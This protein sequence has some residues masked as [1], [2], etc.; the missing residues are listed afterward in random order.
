MLHHVTRFSYREQ[1]L[2]QTTELLCQSLAEVQKKAEADHYAA[3]FVGSG[4][5]E[6]M[7]QST[8]GGSGTLKEQL[9]QIAKNGGKIVV[10]DL[11]CGAGGMSEGAAQALEEI[12]SEL[13]KDVEEFAELHAVNHDEEALRAHR[14]NHSWAIH[15]NTGIETLD[16]TNVV[17]RDVTV[18]LLIA[19]P[20]CTQHSPAKGGGPKD[21]DKRSL[22]REIPIWTEHLDVRNVLVENVPAFRRW[23]PL[24]SNDNVVEEK[25]GELFENWLNDLSIQGFNLE[26][27]VLNAADYG[28]ATSRERLFVAGRKDAG[29]DWPEKTHSKDG[30]GDTEEWRPAAE[31][32]DWDDP[33]DSLWIR[34][35]L[36]GRR[37]PLVN[38]TM[39]RIAEGV[40]RHCDDAL[41]P[42]AEVIEQMGRL[43]EAQEERQDPTIS[44]EE[45][46]V[47]YPLELLRERVVSADQAATAARVQS[48]PFLVKFYGTSTA[49]PVDEPLDT[50]TSGGV[51][52]GLCNPQ[53]IGQHGNSIARDVTE[54]PAP[55]VAKAGGISQ[56]RPETILLRQHN[57]AGAHPIDVEDGPA[58][59]IAKAGAISQTRAESMV[60]PK[61]GLCRRLHSNPAYDPADQP[62]HTV[63]A[64]DTRQGYTLNPLLMQYSHGGSLRDVDEPVPTITTA[65]GG[66]FSLTNPSLIPFYG[67]RS[68]QAPRTHD[69]DEPMPTAVSSKVWGGKVSPFIVEYYGNGRSQPVSDPLPTATSKE[70][71][72]L[73][74]P[75]MFGLGLDLRF[76]MLKPKELAAA[77]GFPDDYEFVGTK[78]DRIKHIGN[79]VPVNL[80]KALCK[81]M[82]VGHQPTL[83]SFTSSSPAPADDD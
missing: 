6:K 53:V 16:P 3:L 32:L 56:C 18:H 48:E 70:R 51:K 5:G 7:S 28:D 62:L 40:R 9:M 4:W 78:T 22:P 20:D 12:A 15:Y 24:D 17:G 52:F 55:T 34:D 35:L 31:I 71:F 19:A 10:I 57:G 14:K 76:R 43:E 74:V 72:A 1:F 2:A 36:D 80:S 39:K 27:R 54:R 69:I 50:V 37:K 81:Q 75:E 38:N 83:D 25:R 63:I 49:R 30:H 47:Q 41:E 59:T 42:F 44:P 64:T 79:A 33:G 23:G 58:P 65:K 29:V 45:Y 60:L 13:D 11:F 67:E 68:T 8:L 21:R 61:N 82:L 46:E 66:V 77:Q 26:H 73:V